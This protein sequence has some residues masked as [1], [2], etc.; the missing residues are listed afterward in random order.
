VPVKDAEL[1]KLIDKL[2]EHYQN[3]I[4]NRYL[5]QGLLGLTIDQ[6]T[7]DRIE[8]LAGPS[9]YH[10]LNGYH[11][12][13]L[14]EMIISSATFV[15]RAHK[16][17]VPNL[18]TSLS[19]GADRDVLRDMVINNFAANLGIYADMINE[20]YMKTVALDRAD[21][22]AGRCVFEGIPGLKDI[23]KLLIAG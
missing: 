1:F 23:G 3:N 5:R 19:G 20:V 10:R 16:E 6:Q 17:L 15:S 13:E 18:R 2:G 22:P 21:H 14:Y 12:E 4:N 8:S 7:W 11:F 9:D